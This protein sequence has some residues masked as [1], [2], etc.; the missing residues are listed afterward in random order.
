[1]QI[2]YDVSQRLINTIDTL[3]LSDN[4]W[5]CTCKGEI[6]DLVSLFLQI[7]L[8]IVI[9]YQCTILYFMYFCSQ[10]LLEKVQDKSYL[11]CGPGSDPA[12]LEKKLVCLQIIDLLPFDSEPLVIIDYSFQ[13]DSLDPEELCPPGSN[14][15]FQEM[16]M[17]LLCG[18]LLILIILVLLN[19]AH[20]A[21]KYRTR[22]QLPWLALKMHWV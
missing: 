9:Q 20:S 14:G 10:N 17:W 12:E 18:L 7:E 21:H 15:E 2:S 1:M 13:I 16:M 8:I 11:Q 4:P 5:K 3:K 6:T 22:G 19:L